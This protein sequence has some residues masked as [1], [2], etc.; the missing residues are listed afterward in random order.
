MAA[1]KF[2]IYD[3]FLE[4][5]DIQA[6]RS[7][8]GIDVRNWLRGYLFGRYIP[9]SDDNFEEKTDAEAQRV[10]FLTSCLTDVNQLRAT[11]PK[12]KI[13]GMYAVY[14][15]LGIPLP[16]VDYRKSVAQVYTDATL[17]MI[18]WSR[19][20]GVLRD[21][22]SVSRN[23]TLPS[24]VPDW[25]DNEVRFTMTQSYATKGSEIPDQL[26]RILS[27]SYGKLNTRGKVVGNVGKL[28]KKL[29]MMPFPTRS[30][31]YTMVRILSSS[32]FHL[33]DDVEFLRLLVCQ[34]EFYRE[35]CS[36]L[37]LNTFLC[38][39]G[40]WFDTLFSILSQGQSFPEEGL[41]EVWINLLS[42]PKSQ[43]DLS[44]GKALAEIWKDN[45]DGNHAAWTSELMHCAVI[46]ASLLSNSVLSG[47]EILPSHGAI[48]D[49]MKEISSNLADCSVVAVRHRA[50]DFETIGTT[51]QSVGLGDT[52]VLL[53]G[54]EWPA[55]L[56][57]M[58]SDWSFIGPA[59][60]LELMD[61][62]AWSDRN[63]QGTGL[64]HFTL[65]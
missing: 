34:I 44:F 31:S 42:Y 8:V 7:M 32:A 57:P 54:A 19:S 65:T 17:A 38:P 14:T 40:N 35:L 1:A 45:D 2:L 47:G 41:F 64:R 56:R 12:D 26:P 24:W 13:Y 33:V 37:Q 9:A 46:A 23:A 60:L 29:L 52:V 63:S 4:Y 55:V 58:G 16:A 50:T 49:L 18:S 43:Y 61:G 36:L 5:L 11:D 6:A 25:N 53:E 3:Q 59:F 22:C 10:T 30:E 21:A 62:Q 20:L 51:F 27:P 28:T 48:L 15:K 39:D